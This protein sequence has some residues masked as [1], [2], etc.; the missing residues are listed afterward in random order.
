MANSGTVRVRKLILIPAAITFGITLLRLTG[1]L[2]DWSPTLFQ[3]QAGGAGAVVGIAWLV[4]VFGVYFALELA[5]AGQS[6]ASVGPA[7]GY[8]LLAVVLTPAVAFLA[9][10]LGVQPRG[11]VF[12]MCL[13]V[14]SLLVCLVAGRGWPALGRV[15]LAYGLAARIPVATLMLFAILGNWGT[16]YD[17]PP[18]GFPAEMGSLRRWLVTGVV[19]QLT[20]WMAFTT[21]VG[22]VLGGL[23]LVVAG[24]RPRR[25]RG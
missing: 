17:A 10:R 11:P 22:A 2:L 4:P 12:L 16:H 25:A 21:V 6:P 23:T 7:L 13:A 14:G 9:G 5:K 18:P 3:R 24:R 19:P 15:L 20:V 8:P 1:E